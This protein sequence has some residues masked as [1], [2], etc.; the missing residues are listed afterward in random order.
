MLRAGLRLGVLTLSDIDPGLI[1][2]GSWLG[3]SEKAL[4]SSKLTENSGGRGFSRSENEKEKERKEKREKRKIG[5][6]LF[7][8]SGF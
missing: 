5:L 3:W 1:R 6:D 7:G 2:G 4:P 8:F